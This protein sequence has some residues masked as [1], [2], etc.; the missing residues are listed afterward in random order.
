MY[1]PLHPAR[2]REAG[3]PL[4]KAVNATIWYS[5]IVALLAIAFFY[6]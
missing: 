3:R 4:A 1:D 5:V 2:A 6:G